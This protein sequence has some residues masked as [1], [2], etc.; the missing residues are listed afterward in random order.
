MN[1]PYRLLITGTRTNL[2]PARERFV[3]NTI[4][5]AIDSAT[6]PGGTPV[7][8]VVIVHGDC[9]TGVD[10]IAARIARTGTWK[11]ITLTEEPHPADWEEYGRAAGPVRNKQMVDLGA[12]ACHGFPTA[13]SRGTWGCLRMAEKAGIPTF[14]H[15]LDGIA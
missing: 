13:H 9:P 12:D 2:S 15:P 14:E 6:Y 4:Y 3:E 11:L 5:A 1:D 10:Q 7:T 8:D